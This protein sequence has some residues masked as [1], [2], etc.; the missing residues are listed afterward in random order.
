VESS[1]SLGLPATPAKAKTEQGQAG[2]ETSWGVVLAVV[3]AFALIVVGGMRW[4]SSEP[5][6]EEG[7]GPMGNSAPDPDVTYGDI[8]A[9]VTVADGEGL[10]EVAAHAGE[11]VRIDGAE[12]SPAPASGELRR[13]VTAG[14]HM[15]HSG[16]QGTERSRIVQ[17]RAGRTAHVSIDGP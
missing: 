14:T 4:L 13:V 5:G 10:L 8:P 16:P 2:K 6:T 15:V 17:V 1:R 12:A 3:A 9:S 7:S 11:P